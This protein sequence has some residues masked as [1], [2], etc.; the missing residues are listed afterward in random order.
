MVQ[1]GQSVEMGQYTSSSRDKEGLKGV[2]RFFLVA[3]L[4]PMD[5]AHNECK[6]DACQSKTYILTCSGWLQTSARTE[7]YLDR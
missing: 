6:S 7:R 1:A 2:P 4:L 3:G 5:G